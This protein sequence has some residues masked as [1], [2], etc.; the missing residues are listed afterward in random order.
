MKEAKPKDRGVLSLIA[1]LGS[2]SSAHGLARIVSSKQTK[3]RLIWTILVIIGLA[4][5][6]VQF[7]MLVKKYLQFQVVEVSEVKDSMP[8]EF[9]A[10]TVCNIEPISLRKV[11]KL[12]SLPNADLKRWLEFVYR[13]KFGKQT[14]HLTSIRAFYENLG[15]EAEY[16]RHELK[17]FIKHCRFNKDQC[18]S[19]NFTMSFDGNYY[20]CFT[21]NRGHYDK[22]LMHSTGP[23]NGLSL[24]LAVDN[25]NPPL[26]TYGVYNIDSN[27]LHSA[28]VRVVVHAPNTMPSPVNH[29]ID[30]PP[31]YSS[32]IG[33]KAV[34]HTR[35]SEPYGNCS[36][37][38]L[39]GA[40]SYN[41]TFFT[42]L[43][44]CKQR[45]IIEKCRC[46]SSGLPEVQSSANVP[47]CGY[48]EN[49]RDMI[50]SPNQYPHDVY[51]PRLI[52]EEHVSHEMTTDRSYEV[53][54]KCVQPCHETTFQ[55][56]V[57]LSYWP[58]EF[59]Q[60]NILE[61][62]YNGSIDQ[63]RL[64]E[65]YTV[66]SNLTKQES[67]KHESSKEKENMEAGYSSQ[68]R[69]EA[70]RASKLIRQ[71]LLRV[72]IYLEDLSVVEFRQMPAYDLA[73]LFADIGGTM[74]LWMGISVL[75]IMELVEL[76][77]RLILLM[78]RSETRQMPEKQTIPNGMVQP[79]RRQFLQT[80]FESSV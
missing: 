17:D 59:Y 34:L 19:S 9:P 18:G 55:K 23:E 53:S 56:S 31:G 27:I 21:F 35:L 45:I 54:C 13:F 69:E 24:I 30:V 65:A 43:Q 5:A 44:M 67:M 77:I 80:G 76:V 8:V 38:V 15:D 51:L 10:I 63:N 32:S 64:K 52:C 71:N 48:I 14:A 29:G 58:L 3:R 49:W 41:N 39:E 37:S 25:D 20:S 57:S 73:D 68:E 62:L 50:A 61:L 60:L 12:L 7:S 22:I 72:N 33:L 70:D 40:E 11:R 4:A 79:E 6:T 75:T 46:K 66:L 26:G 74:G 28:G 2:E 36:N 78:F 1:E 47:F 42:C 16:V